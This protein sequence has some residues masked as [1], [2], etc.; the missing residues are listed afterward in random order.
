MT[1]RGFVLRV[2]DV[3]PRAR[4]QNWLRDRMND[5]AEGWNVFVKAANAGVFDVKAAKT[6]TKRWKLIEQSGGWPT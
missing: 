6:L 5:F 2:A 4:D 1:R 3:M